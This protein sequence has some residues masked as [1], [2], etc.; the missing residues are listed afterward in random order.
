MFFVAIILIAVCLFVGFA[1]QGVV[2]LA[3]GLMWGALALMALGSFLYSVA[4]LLT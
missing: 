1:H 4:L 3:L 2:E